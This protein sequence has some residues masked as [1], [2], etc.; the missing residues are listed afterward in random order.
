MYIIG[1]I[2]NTEIKLFIFK[3]NF[4]LL[5]KFNIKTEL[6]SRRHL[7]SKLS[8]SFLKKNKFK[9]ILFCS[10]VP[11]S[12]K[13][14]KNYLEINTKIKCIELKELEFSKILKIL[15]NKKQIGS[16]RLANALG[17]FNKNKNFI[18]IDFGTATTF[19][20][21]N[22]DKYIGG[23]IAPGVELSLKS[24]SRR[25][26]LIP[27]I[28]FTKINKIIG[29]NTI[30]SVKSGFYWGYLGLINNIIELIK[31]E[32]NRK[33]KII[34][35]GGL[36]HLFKT[37]LKYKASINKDLTLKGLIKILKIFNIYE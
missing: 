4:K 28:K 34:L 36:S 22:K 37:S 23:V 3:E 6:L 8:S 10:V 31:K 30:S 32:T 18:V 21:I 7:K 16:D 13:I 35:T 33:Y 29:K 17:I 9:K 2:G 15:V 20:V 26:S 5:K 12:Y 27:V 11:K 24:L 25:A 19:D 14:I 1:D